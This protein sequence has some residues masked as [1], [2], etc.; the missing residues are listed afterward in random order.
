MLLFEG[1]GMIRVEGVKLTN[2]PGYNLKMDLCHDVTVSGITIYNPADDIAGTDGV[3]P[4]LV[5]ERLRKRWDDSSP[6]TD[7]ID[8]ESCER[9]LISRCRIDTG[10]DCV[11][12]TSQDGVVSRDT[13]ITDC[14]FLHGHGCVI[15]SQ[16]LGGVRNLTVRRCT[17][18]GTDV[19][20]GLESARDRGGLNENLFYH[21]LVMKNVGE[22]IVI[23]SYYPFGARFYKE[24][25]DS[26]IAAFG[27][28]KPQPVTSTTPRWH[29]IQIR[30]VT[31]TCLWEA[32]VIRG[33]PE[34]PIEGL[35]LE[36]ISIKAPEGI[37]MYNAQNVTARNVRV[38][39]A[40][41]LPFVLSDSVHGFTQPA[42]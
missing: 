30:N 42:P 38:T 2:A 1:C 41:G 27:N 18:E 19:G 37:R 15:G 17:F 20:L 8:P 36:N 12:V 9:V 32:G 25:D 24:K 31:A 29:N 6:N 23:T 11:A 35:T 22:P 26:D 7:G 34:M 5:M 40:H 4:H 39:A 10:D 3:D 13:L 33:L 21:D 14:T 28:D 16:E